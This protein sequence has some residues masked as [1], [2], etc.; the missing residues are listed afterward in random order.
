MSWRE[1]CE[2]GC[3]NVTAEQL[4]VFDSR[5]RN[6]LDIVV[7]ITLSDEQTSSASTDGPVRSDIWT[8]DEMTC[9]SSVEE[10]SRRRTLNLVFKTLSRDDLVFIPEPLF[11]KIRPT[12]YTPPNSRAS[13]CSYCT[14]RTV[15]Q[16]NSDLKVT[17]S[18]CATS[19]RL[20]R[21]DDDISSHAE[22]EQ[23]PMLR[24]AW[25]RSL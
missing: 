10:Q 12:S 5:L 4:V 3:G 21:T 9:T 25:V 23:S 6:E 15:A 11:I 22:K 13:H 8:K 1:T 24:N 18:M 7:A 17:R 14:S 2:L 16:S 20:H 19:I